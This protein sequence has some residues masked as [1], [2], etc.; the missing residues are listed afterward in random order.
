MGPLDGALLVSA[1]NAAYSGLLSGLL[2]SVRSHPELAGLPVGVLDV[3]LSP[4][5]RQELEAAG[6]AVVRPGWDLEVPR[7]VRAKESLKA[8]VSR[9][10]LPRHFPGHA[11]YLWVDADAWVQRPAALGAFAAAARGG[12]LAV[13]PEVDVGYDHLLGG[14]EL[15]RFLRRVYSECLGWR[16]GRRLARYPALNSGAF[17][18]EAGAP[19]WRA[20]QEALG[21]VLRRTASFYGEQTAFNAVVHLDGLPVRLLP[22]THNWACGHGR[23]ALDEETGLLVTPYPPF[24]PLDVVHLTAWSKDGEHVLPTVAGGEVRRRL[25]YP[26]LGIGRS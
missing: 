8:N 9:P 3:G 15:P 14:D 12:R 23:P 25:T 21:R 22:A 11:L 7:A 20:W 5:Q 13:V 1:A 18:L 2:G 4:P 17:A 24:T 10:F 6:V 26:G 16:A 19:H